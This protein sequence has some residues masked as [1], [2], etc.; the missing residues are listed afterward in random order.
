MPKNE[1]N[2]NEE[3]GKCRGLLG[4]KKDTYRRHLVVHKYGTST[5]ILLAP[6]FLGHVAFHGWLT[7]KPRPTTV[8]PFVLAYPVI[9]A[10]KPPPSPQPC[11]CGVITVRECIKFCKTLSFVLLPPW[12]VGH[13]TVFVHLMNLSCARVLHNTRFCAKSKALLQNLSSPAIQPSS[14]PTP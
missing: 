12:T 4:N 14:H 2:L 1:F 10:T 3:R 6:R 9:P 11:V 7:S 5:H 13:F 8:P